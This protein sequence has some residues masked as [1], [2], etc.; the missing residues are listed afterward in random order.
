M[1]VPLINAMGERQCSDT[2]FVFNA[3]ASCLAPEWAISLHP[4]TSVFSVFNGCLYSTVSRVR[5]LYTTYLVHS[6]HLRQMLNT[7]N[8][9]VCAMKIHEAERL[10]QVSL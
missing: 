7:C 10:S 4:R 3:F 2:L 1:A 6:Q 9:N 8:A 5:L